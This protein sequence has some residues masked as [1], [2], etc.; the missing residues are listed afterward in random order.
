[1]TEKNS[2][3]LFAFSALVHIALVVFVGIRFVSARSVAE[4]QIAF[5]D[6]L[7]AAQTASQVYEEEI[8]QQSEHES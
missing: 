3:G 4:Q 1:M 8:V 5:G 2:G 7:S 6:A